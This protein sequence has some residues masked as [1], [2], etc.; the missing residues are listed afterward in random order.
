MM[1][2]TVRS[3]LLLLAGIPV[4]V[5]PVLLGDR[6]WVA[7]FSYS[8]AVLVAIG[9]DS[10]LVM[11]R[12]QSGI[13]VT[14]PAILYI[15]NP[16]RLQV[17]IRLFVRPR[18]V[19]IEALCE[20]GPLL[21]PQDQLQA[22][23]EGGRG[24]LEIPLVA[25][26]R[27]TAQV[28]A[29]WLRWSGPLGLMRCQFRHRLDL[30]IPVVPDVQAVR[31]AA[32]RFF[33]SKD[34]LAGEKME[35]YT[36]DG[37]EFERLREFVPGLDHRAMD[38]KASARHRKLLCREFRAERN[39]QVVIAFDT[40]HLMSEPVAGIPKLDHAI[41]A[42]LLL[43]YF[44][45]RAGDRV[46]LYGFDKGAN[47]YCEPQGGLGSFHRLQL[48]A[49]E[50]E[51]SHEETNFTLGLAEL[52]LRIRRRSLVVLLTDFVDT[53]TAGLMVEDLQRLSRHHLVVFVALSNPEL[54]TCAAAVPS[55]IHRMARSVVA[56]DFVREREVA[57]RGLARH[58]IQA[59][60]VAPHEV[61]PQLLNRYLD[62]KR[63]ELIA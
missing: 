4:A 27:G 42:G 24:L 33:G 61:S 50:L 43:A 49:A 59:L 39:H 60:D 6:F 53:I 44:S 20:L 15:G 57:L 32:L 26:R 46:G 40:G 5:L 30:E 38:W 7:W 16:D 10:L 34:L 17:E 31:R 55:T 14:P 45:L 41:N 25:R 21:Q 23:L 3:V 8:L 51:Y 54:T 19:L 12:R 48:A 62:I 35:R 9:A 28:S 36:G 11:P 56:L 2:P 63:R 52:S 13:K 58:G 22:E 47:L 37:S 1:R 29:L 18:P